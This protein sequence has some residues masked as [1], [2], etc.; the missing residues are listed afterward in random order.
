MGRFGFIKDGKFWTRLVW[1]AV[2]IIIIASFNRVNFT[3][4]QAVKFHSH[5][6]KNSALIAEIEVGAFKVFFYENDDE[7]VTAITE[8]VLLFWKL[9][10]VGTFEKKSD[11][12]IKIVGGCSV[13]WTDKDKGVTTIAVQSFDEK[14]T[15]ITMG[16]GKDF[17]SKDITYGEVAVFAW[18]RGL[19]WSDLNP[20]AYSGDGTPLYKL[21]Q[22]VAGG[23]VTSKTKWMP[24]E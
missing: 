13:Q 8:R 9:N 12:I 2:I 17:L 22:E 21:G 6:N 1:I 3:A 15:S 23:M 7:Y 5:I 10:T 18:D 24:I 19:R 11:D 14:V 4:L 16:E 20:A